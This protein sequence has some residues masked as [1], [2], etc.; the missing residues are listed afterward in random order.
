[1]RLKFGTLSWFLG[2]SSQ[3]TSESV[4]FSQNSYLRNFLKRFNKTDWKSV[5][6]PTEKLAESNILMSSGN[7]KGLKYT[8]IRELI[9][10]LICVMQAT[11]PDLS[12]SVNIF[13]RYQN[14]PSQAL[15]KCL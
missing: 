7:D 9:G 13:S 2:I 14:K 12:I 15:W 6:T 8:P 4:N 1:M 5:K 11:Y 10:C 3:I